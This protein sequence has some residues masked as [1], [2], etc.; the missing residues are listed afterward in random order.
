MSL[1]I[2]CQYTYM[3]YLYSLTRSQRKSNL[4]VQL[5]NQ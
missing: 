2:Q 4:R 3:Q 5:E 1:L